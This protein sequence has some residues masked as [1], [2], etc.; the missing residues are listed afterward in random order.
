[1]Y[2]PCMLTEGRIV[3]S[4]SIATSN[5]RAIFSIS[6]IYQLVILDFLQLKTLVLQSG[7][8]GETLPGQVTSSW[9]RNGEEGELQT[10]FTCSL[11]THHKAKPREL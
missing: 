4:H 2:C 3:P 5:Y 7:H 6:I 1:M 9:L 11:F 8:G 10:P